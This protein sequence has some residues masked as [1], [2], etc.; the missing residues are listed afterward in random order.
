[1]NDDGGFPGCT[2]DGEYLAECPVEGGLLGSARAGAK[3]LTFL[4]EGAELDAGPECE[5]LSEGPA[6]V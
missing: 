4:R 1:V 3:R 5:G 2:G 6:R